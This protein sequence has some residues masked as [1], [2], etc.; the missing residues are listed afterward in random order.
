MNLP[1]L[2]TTQ[3]FR[4]LV[5]ACLVATTFLTASSF[6]AQEPDPSEIALDYLVR[7]SDRMALVHYAVN[8]DGTANQDFSSIAHRADLPLPLA[9]TVKIMLLATYAR[10]VAA[11]HLNPSE[12][13]TLGDWQ[14]HYHWNFGN[15]PE[16]LASLGIA[17]DELGLALDPSTTVPLDLIVR[18]MIRYSD[19]AATDYLLSRLGKDHFMATMA[20]AGLTAQE[21]Q[22]TLMGLT[23]TLANHEQG[24]ITDSRLQTLLAMDRESYVAEAERLRDLYLDPEWRQEEILWVLENDIHIDPATIATLLDT[25]YPKGTAREY[26]RV[27][28][29]VITDNF[30]SPTI[31]SIMRPHLERDLVGS[32][33]EDLFFTMGTKGGDME[34]TLTM[35]FYTIPKVGELAGQPVVSVL[36]LNG[37]PPELGASEFGEPAEFF[38]LRLWL[39]AEWDDQVLASLCT[40]DASTAC[41][42]NGRFRVQLA[43]KDY[44]GHEGTGQV[45][46]VNS[47]DS[48]LFWMFGANNWEFLVKVLDGCTVNGNFWF[49]SAAATD[50]EYTLSV[51]DMAEGITKEYQNSLGN[52]SPA[53][54]DTAAFATCGES[55]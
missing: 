4:K 5:S 6:Q 8:P 11:G 21:T 15:H 42:N 43:W 20:E 51:T 40:P 3:S 18:V 16:A 22:F 55:D 25:H 17:T 47:A 9:S 49:L 35:A 33:L 37:L 36:F 41:L 7:H 48:G 13:I 32:G 1:Q 34:G 30:L 28:A 26:A 44:Q 54:I 45:A 53:I 38:L 27:M 12:A 46:P 50:V 14:Q 29:E 23:M 52:A 2:H 10:E 39:D 24:P 19:N 31:S